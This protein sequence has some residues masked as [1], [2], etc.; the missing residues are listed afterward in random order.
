MPPPR[1]RKI[2][3]DD[4]DTARSLGVMSYYQNK[5]S[6][7]AEL[8]SE[9]VAA[10]SQDGEVYYYL[11][12]DYLQMKQSAL[13]KQ[14]LQKALALNIPEKLAAEAKKALASAP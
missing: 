7:S 9:S 2:Y 10:N 3:H 1:K 5:Y 6:R 8:L 13:S 4:P 11:G 14:N 12:M